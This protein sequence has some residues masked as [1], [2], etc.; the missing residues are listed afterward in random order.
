M[1]KETQDASL[2]SLTKK[3]VRQVAEAAAE[4]LLKWK[5][6][7]MDVGGFN[8]FKMT[9]SELRSYLKEEVH[10]AL[11]ESEYW[12]G[13]I[14]PDVL[15]ALQDPNSPSNEPEP[16]IWQKQYESSMRRIG[17]LCEQLKQL[18]ISGDVNK[19]QDFFERTLLPEVQA[20]ES[21]KANA[22]IK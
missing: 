12:P 22:G 3:E 13:D 4:H 18:A 8:R 9:E 7:H 19:T 11:M 10:K 15:M 20:I 5:Q 6:K 1:Y 16:N 21:S 17:S 2:L 14:N